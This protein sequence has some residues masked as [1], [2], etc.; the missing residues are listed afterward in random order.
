MKN[1]LQPTD[2]ELFT[3]IA[4]G[5]EGAFAQ[6]YDRYLPML[7]P[8][9]Y[10][11]VKSDAS[12][13]DI[14]QE[15]FLAVWLGRSKLVEIEN[16]KNWILKICYNRSFTFIK[17]KLLLSNTENAAYQSNSQI[18]QQ[19]ATEELVD[20]SETMRLI[21]EAIHA[22]P[23]QSRRIYQLNRDEGMSIAEIAEH[24]KINPQSVK[25]SLG[26]SGKAIK[27]YLLAK[28]FEIPLLLLLY[29]MH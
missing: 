21:Q 5:D 23:N 20:F 16:P 19:N 6:I 24:L 28:G 2:K 29:K 15:T 4:E 26:R 18:Q 7:Y 27:D 3:Q 22:L 25:N 9:I 10:K 8:I 13:R 11:I 17:R 1:D 12:V 14:A